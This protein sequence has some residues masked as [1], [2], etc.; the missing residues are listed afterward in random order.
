MKNYRALVKLRK[1]QFDRAEQAVASANARLNALLSEKEAVRAQ[2]R[3]A[4]PPERGEGRMFH[5]IASHRDSARAR[6]AVLDAQID[7]ARRDKAE[8]EALLA[9][10]LRAW[11]QAKSLESAVLAQ[12]LKKRKRIEQGELDEIAGQRFWR[13]TREGER[14]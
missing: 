14:A 2:M 1:Q 13:K 5:L 9:Q 10:A 6:L 7:V 4:A 8:K 3:E 11:E 12:W